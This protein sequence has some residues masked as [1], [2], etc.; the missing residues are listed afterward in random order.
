MRGKKPSC[1][2]WKHLSSH[3]LNERI[4]T[5]NTNV[6]KGMRKKNYIYVYIYVYTYIYTK[7]TFLMPDCPINLFQWVWNLLYWQPHCVNVA[8]TLKWMRGLCFLFLPPS[9]ILANS[10]YKPPLWILHVVCGSSICHSVELFTL[11][12]CK[13]LSLD[14]TD[15]IKT[16]KT[17]QSI[18]NRQGCR[19]IKAKIFPTLCL[20][21]H[22]T[23]ILWACVYQLWLVNFKK[24]NKW[25]ISR[26]IIRYKMF[27]LIVPQRGNPTEPARLNASNVPEENSTTNI[28][29]WQKQGR[30]HHDVKKRLHWFMHF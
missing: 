20:K 15:T 8:P 23:H 16:C 17:F 28:R 18:A 2:L 3:D 5:D 7:M 27:L 24:Y 12:K 10:K 14:Y 6:I 26:S 21:T 25:R 1:L 11:W 29:Y 13:Q 9:L 4:F 19:H 30:C 22:D